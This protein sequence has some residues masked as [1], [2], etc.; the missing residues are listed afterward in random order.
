MTR[1]AM[2]SM[3]ATRQSQTAILMRL[4]ERS[5]YSLRLISRLRRLACLAQARPGS[6]L[7][8]IRKGP[9]TCWRSFAARSPVVRRGT[10]FIRGDTGLRLL[11]ARSSP[12]ARS[13]RPVHLI[14]SIRLVFIPDGAAVNRLSR[15][16]HFRHFPIRSS[17][18]RSSRPCR[19]RHHL[20]SH[21]RISRCLRAAAW[22]GRRA[23]HLVMR[24]DPLVSQR[25]LGQRAIPVSGQTR[26]VY[27][28]NQRSR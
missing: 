18:R 14:R 16:E 17:N 24:L 26:G 7:R 25:R 19:T 6:G 8:S 1:L 9:R 28:R 11:L 12:W 13:I 4:S 27:P 3:P 15:L 2:F 21:P 5:G 23:S 22:A 10:A 20:S